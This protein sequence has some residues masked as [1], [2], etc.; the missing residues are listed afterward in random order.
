MRYYD[1]NGNQIKK[2]CYIRINNNIYHVLESPYKN[3]YI[4]HNNNYCYLTNA[5]DTSYI[6]VIK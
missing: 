2:D 6:L 5:I 1:C 4:I 3:L